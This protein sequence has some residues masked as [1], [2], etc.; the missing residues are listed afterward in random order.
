MWLDLNRQEEVRRYCYFFLKMCFKVSST[1]QIRNF[2]ASPFS[3]YRKKRLFCL[4]KFGSTYVQKFFIVFE[5]LRTALYKIENISR[6]R[7][8]RHQNKKIAI[9]LYNFAFILKIWCKSRAPFSRNR[10][11][12]INNNRENETLE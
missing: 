4:N 3:W 12:K 1:Y 2:G 6:D 10:M 7:K 5:I 11:Q 9:R 8:W